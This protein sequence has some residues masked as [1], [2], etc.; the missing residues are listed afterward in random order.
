MGENIGV[1]FDEEGY[2]VGVA[3]HGSHAQSLVVSGVNIGAGIE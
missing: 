2:D 1:S 3:I